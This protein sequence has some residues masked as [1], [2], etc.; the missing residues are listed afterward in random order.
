MHLSL[1]NHVVLVQFS[2]AIFLYLFFMKNCL[3]SRLNTTT[4][5]SLFHL[6]IYH[7]PWVIGF[8]ASLFFF[9]KHDHRFP[10]CF[11]TFQYILGLPWH[12][13]KSFI[14][15]LHP[16]ILRMSMQN[17]ALRE[18]RQ[19]SSLAYERPLTLFLLSSKHDQRSWDGSFIF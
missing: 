12:Y 11:P 4:V 16:P 7:I 6:I 3:S 8:I 17:S 1:E 18:A 2:S 9:P 13:F 15:H 19:A 10:K 5:T 14:L